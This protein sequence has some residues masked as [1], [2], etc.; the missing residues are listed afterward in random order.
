MSKLN[1]RVRLTRSCAAEG[2]VSILLSRSPSK[3]SPTEPEEEL[4]NKP[5][6]CF[7]CG[8][9]N[10][11]T[12]GQ[13][14]SLYLRQAALF[15]KYLLSPDFLS[16]L[17]LSPQVV[18]GMKNNT[19]YAACAPC[20]SFIKEL[21]DFQQQIKALEKDILNVMERTRT[22]MLLRKRSSV[23]KGLFLY[24]IIVQ[25]YN[26]TCLKQEPQRSR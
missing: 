24:F 11:A 10:I 16:T 6:H 19:E 9:D 20:L 25:L 18:K 2:A 1:P 13:A 3:S 23:S 26:Q 17:K 8:D 4:R 14:I 5:E 12:Q 21:W 22:S 7:V 15:E